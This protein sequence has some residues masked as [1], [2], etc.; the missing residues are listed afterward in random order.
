MT[1]VEWIQ[2]YVKRMLAGGS[3]MN[4][5]QLVDTA[6]AGCDAT[7]ANGCLNPDEWEDPESI[8][9]EHLKD[10][11]LEPPSTEIAG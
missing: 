5:S 8:A 11:G 1:R 7:E 4:E 6:E 9:D 10:E 3:W 2:R